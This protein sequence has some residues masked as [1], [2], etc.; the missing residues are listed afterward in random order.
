MIQNPYD[1]TSSAVYLNNIRTRFS[2]PFNI[3]LERIMEDALENNRLSSAIKTFTS[4]LLDWWLSGK[5]NRHYHHL[6]HCSFIISGPPLQRHHLCLWHIELVILVEDLL[7]PVQ[8]CF[9]VNFLVGS[10]Q[11]FCCCLWC[12][13][14]WKSFFLSRVFGF[15]YISATFLFPLMRFLGPQNVFH[16]A[17][18]SRF[19]PMKSPITIFYTIYLLMKASKKI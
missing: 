17:S 4:V 7:C 12:L 16:W 6:G 19:Y 11:I 15:F 2:N 8:Q 14:C 1:K 3:I 10:W 5:R 13:D 18:M 9:V